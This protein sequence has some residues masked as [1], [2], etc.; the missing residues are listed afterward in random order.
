MLKDGAF[1]PDY[2]TVIDDPRFT[3]LYERITARVDSMRASFLANP[4][5]P[6]GYLR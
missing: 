1:D 5:L 6:A 2:K 3:A 4:E